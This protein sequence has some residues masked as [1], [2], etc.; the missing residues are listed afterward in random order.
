MKRFSVCRPIPTPPNTA[1]DLNSPIGLLANGISVQRLDGFVYFW[2]KKNAEILL[3]LREA[4]ADQIAR[5]IQI[6]LRVNECRLDTALNDLIGINSLRLSRCTNEIYGLLGH[7]L[8]SILGVGAPP[9]GLLN[10]NGLI[11]FRRDLPPTLVINP[12]TSL[13]DILGG[14]I[15]VPLLLD[16]IAQKSILLDA[17]GFYNTQFIFQ[18]GIS[19]IQTRSGFIIGSILGDK[20]LLVRIRAALDVLITGL[21]PTSLSSLVSALLNSIAINEPITAAVQVLYTSGN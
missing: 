7:I 10:L 21:S 12:R 3:T 17:A 5:E 20:T 6:A 16:A 15:N 11:V 4:Q 9:T 1:V 2:N 18:D 19:P 13:L 14:I 8:T